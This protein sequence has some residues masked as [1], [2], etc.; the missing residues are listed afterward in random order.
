[1]KTPGQ[2]SAKLNTQ[3]ADRKPELLKERLDGIMARR[4]ADMAVVV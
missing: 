1:M 3:R 4:D 2:F